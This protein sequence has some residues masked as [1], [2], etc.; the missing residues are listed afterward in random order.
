MTKTQHIFFI[1]AG[2]GPIDQLKQ[3]TKKDAGD[4]LKAAGGKPLVLLFDIPDNCGFYM[5][6]IAEATTEA[7]DKINQSKESGSEKR[8]QLG[9]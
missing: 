2:G 3:M 5:P 4:K 7:L 8:M 9:R 1:A 6:D